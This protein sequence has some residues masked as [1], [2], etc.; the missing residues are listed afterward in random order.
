M[1]LLTKTVPVFADPRNVTTPATDSGGRA[2]GTC[3][4]EIRGYKAT[5]S[6]RAQSVVDRFLSFVYKTLTLLIMCYH[7]IRQIAQSNDVRRRIYKRGELEN[8]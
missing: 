2:A 3:N 5:I 4:V 7:T 6:S 1:C 8:D